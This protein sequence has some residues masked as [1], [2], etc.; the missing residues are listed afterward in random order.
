[1]KDVRQMSRVM[2]TLWIDRESDHVQKYCFRQ[3]IS[4]YKESH[5]LLYI[6][7]IMTDKHLFSLLLFQDMLRLTRKHC[8][9]KQIHAPHEMQC[10]AIEFI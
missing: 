1:M 7:A 3:S 10:K 9:C 5:E 8:E 4:F 6:V 2:F